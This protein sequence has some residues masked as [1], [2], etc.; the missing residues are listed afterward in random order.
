MGLG[1]ADS[2]PFLRKMINPSKIT[3]IATQTIL[4]IVM[5]LLFP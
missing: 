2:F 3:A 4:S 1:Y 5:N